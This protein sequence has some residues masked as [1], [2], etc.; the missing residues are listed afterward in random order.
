MVQ[1]F[2]FQLSFAIR[3]IVLYCIVGSHIASDIGTAFSWGK[4]PARGWTA[5][6]P[7]TSNMGRATVCVLW[8]DWDQHFSTDTRWTHCVVA[9]WV[10]GQTMILYCW[11]NGDSQLSSIQLGCASEDVLL[12]FM[13]RWHMCVC[14]FEAKTLLFS[15]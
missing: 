8:S 7:V 11:T 6:Y 5:Q 2:L 1:N 4:L 14:L 10:L 3:T 13:L 15:W 12:S 9:D